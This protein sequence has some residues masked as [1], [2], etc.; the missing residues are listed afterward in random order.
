MRKV[1]CFLICLLLVVAPFAS[2]STEDPEIEKRRWEAQATYIELSKQ[3][4]ALMKETITVPVPPS[5]SVSCADMDKTE[6]DSQSLKSFIEAFGAPERPLCTQMLDVQKQ[7]QAG[8]AMPDYTKEAALT[9]R[10]GQKAQQLIKDYGQNLEKV[11][12]IAMA[13]MQAATD[14]Q[15]LGLDR[16]ER[17]TALMEAVGAM[18]EAAIDKL[19]RMLVEEHDYGTVK[20]ILDA[21]RASLLLSSASGVDTE[22]ILSRLQNALRFELEIVYLSDWKVLRFEEKATLQL[23]PVYSTELL[24][25]E[26]NGNGSLVSFERDAEDNYILSFTASDFPVQ[27]TLLE[28]L[29][30]E[31]TVN[32]KLSPFYP[33]SEIA[34]T[35]DSSFEA[36]FLREGWLGAHEGRLQDGLFVF[37]LTLRNLNALPV[38]ESIETIVTEGLSTVLMIKLTHNLRN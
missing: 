32:L 2:S 18:Y 38:E 5:T 35:E 13:A 1:L 36:P 19:F 30:C 17:S 21:A 15:L 27:A 7:L 22:K 10:L 37:P 11:P 4:D 9:D 26:G 6:T 8:G 34:H 16:A 33:T 29:P 14:M 23:A 20:P 24:K 31:G 12:A 3:A 25:L 28:F